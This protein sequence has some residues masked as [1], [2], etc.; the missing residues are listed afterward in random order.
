MA[1]NRFHF[2]PNIKDLKDA[3]V[4]DDLNAE[5]PA[6]QRGFY[7]HKS[8]NPLLMHFIDVDSWD[9]DSYEN[10]AAFLT[11]NTE[12]SASEESE[13]KSSEEIAFDPAEA[14]RHLK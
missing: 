13:E 2:H 3:C 6:A 14:R 12:G 7:P 4:A 9:S 1:Q 11:S 10:G 5:K 8:K